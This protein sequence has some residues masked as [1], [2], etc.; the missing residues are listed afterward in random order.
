MPQYSNTR[1]DTTRRSH[2]RT[3][4][5]FTLLYALPEIVGTKAYRKPEWVQH[6]EELKEALQGKP[7]LLNEIDTTRNTTTTTS[8]RGCGAVVSSL[9]NCIFHNNHNHVQTQIH[10]FTFTFDCSDQHN[11]PVEATINFYCTLQL[12]LHVVELHAFVL[13]SFRLLFC[14]RSSVPTLSYIVFSR[15]QH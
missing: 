7:S 10:V 6:M 5:T 2:Y 12:M 4:L 14:L 8:S 15:V 11:L 1:P 13:M 3:E 9:Q